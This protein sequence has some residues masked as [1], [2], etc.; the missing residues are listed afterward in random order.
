MGNRV[1][2][3]ANPLVTSFTRALQRHAQLDPLGSDPIWLTGMMPSS[4]GGVISLQ[5]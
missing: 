2:L 3:P 1:L 4:A 5:S